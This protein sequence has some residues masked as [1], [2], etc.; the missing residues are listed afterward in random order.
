MNCVVPEEDWLFGVWFLG[1]VLRFC[2]EGLFLWVFF[3]LG[4]Q[5]L[6]TGFVFNNNNNKRGFVRE[7]LCKGA[8]IQSKGRKII[9]HNHYL[10]SLSIMICIPQEK[11]CFITYLQ[12]TYMH[13]NWMYFWGASSTTTIQQFV[14]CLLQHWK[15]KNKDEMINQSKSCRELEIGGK[16]I[17]L[18]LVPVEKNNLL[19]QNVNS[20]QQ[21]YACVCSHW[22]WLIPK[23]I[24]LTF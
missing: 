13:I 2:W 1:E 5:I 18:C 4:F 7:L 6:C 15:E 16:N 22:R 21:C 8:E 12:P 23:E 24:T 14:Q 20:L 3:P 9:F 11:I 10:S 17:V 19:S